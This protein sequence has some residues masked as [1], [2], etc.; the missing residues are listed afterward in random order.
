[1]SENARILVVDDEL[2]MLTSIRRQLKGKY[3]LF[4]AQSGQEALDILEKEKDLALV[5]SDFKMPRMNG[6]QLLSKAREIAPD[7]VR[8]MLTGQA[9]MEA[10]VTIINEGNIFRF[11][12]KPCAP[13]LLMKNLDDGIVQYHLIRSEKDLLGKTLGGSLQVMADLLVLAK[14]Q[15]FNRGVRI[16][17]M[18]QKMMKYV[19]IE[20][21]W[22]IEIASIMSQVGCVT[23]PDS[24]LEKI[25]KNMPVTSEEKSSYLQH[26][27]I[28]SEILSKI[29]RM[30]KV[31]EILL[32]QEKYYDGSG[33][34]KDEIKLEKIPLE[35]RILKTVIDHDQLVQMGVS[36]EEAVEE[37][38]KRT[39]M[40]DLSVLMALGNVVKQK[41]EHRKFVIKKVSISEMNSKMF[42]A[43]DVVSASGVIIG[44]RRQR[45]TLALVAA[46][47]N[48]AKNKEITEPIGILIYAD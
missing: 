8:M 42:L 20:N 37:L 12:T 28:S 27:R 14:P 31:A 35:S 45:V 24:I 13:D 22:R 2:N 4:T 39:G 29:P 7:T 10:I 36:P 30:E 23:V 26:V 25:Y 44:T 17:G 5:L 38:L 46:L 48:Y 34:P 33:Y 19:K 9:D 21:T 47:S 11:L 15:A 32:Y 1:M 16:R 3:E 41:D 18:V 40:Y 43:D 6:A